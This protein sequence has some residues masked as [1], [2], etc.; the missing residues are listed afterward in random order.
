MKDPIDMQSYK[1]KLPNKEADMRSQVRWLVPENS[2][3]DVR[4]QPNSLQTLG[5]K[6]SIRYAW[7]DLFCIPQ[8]RSKRAQKEVSQQAAIFGGAAV[9]VAWQNEVMSR[10]VMLESIR[11]LLLQSLLQPAIFD[12]YSNDNLQPFERLHQM[13]EEIA[14]KLAGAGEPSL[15]NY[16]EEG[17]GPEDTTDITGIGWFSS[18]WILQEAIL[19][20]D[21]ILASRDWE[22][23]T[24]DGQLPI[25][26]D[27]VIYLTYN[28]W[29]TEE[30]GPAI[31]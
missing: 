13:Q 14:L 5:R 4:E 15:C 22:F 31:I 19:R 7:I 8:D 10:E 17:Q 20:P 28:F 26:L 12:C 2:R 3:F 23:F 11:W 6:L 16:A 27:A 24:R 1:K 21:M 25:S 30:C 9:A 18:L 29:H